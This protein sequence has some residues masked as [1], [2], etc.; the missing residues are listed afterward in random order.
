MDNFVT[1]VHNRKLWAYICLVIMY[2]AIKFLCMQE[3]SKMFTDLT[4][5]KIDVDENSV[6]NYVAMYVVSWL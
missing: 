4:F 6:S 2:I 5:F 1:Y 3:F